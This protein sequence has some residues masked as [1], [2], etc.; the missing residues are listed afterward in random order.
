[1]KKALRLL[2]IFVSLVLGACTPH[3][4][5]S[6][7][8]STDTSSDITTSTSAVGISDCC[9]EPPVS[10]TSSVMSSSSSAPTSTVNPVVAES[11]WGQ[12]AAQACYDALGI[13]F[14]YLE[15]EGFEYKVTTDDFGDKAVW[16]YLYYDTQEIAEEKIVDYAWAAYEQDRYECV[17][18]PTW[19]TDY[20]DYSRW[21]QNVLYADKV[22]SDKYAIELQVLASL[23]N[24]NDKVMGCLG[25]YGFSYIPNTDPTKFPAY[26]VEYVLW[27]YNPVPDLGLDDMTYSFS[28]DMYEG[29]RIL[30]IIAESKKHGIEMEEEYFNKLLAAKYRIFR[31][32]DLD[33]EFTD[34]MFT[35]ED[36]NVY[37]D[38]EDNYCFYAYPRDNSH[39]VYFEYD[40]NNQWL[41]IEVMCLFED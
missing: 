2:P 37:P 26:P 7:V 4:S 21:E 12:E 6:G 35:L 31:Y 16:F 3:G 13:V 20:T 30:I 1:M 28:F 15:A 18:Q 25:I 17:V 9:T 14:P 8:L 32:S 29:K 36:N 40:L 24:Y 38:Y 5:T 27:E 34:E 23:K 33:D 19:F 41:H 10:T 11:K 22:I 39:L